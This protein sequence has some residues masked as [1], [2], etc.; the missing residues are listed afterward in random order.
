MQ[1]LTFDHTDIT[2]KGLAV[3]APLRRLRDISLQSPN[4]TAAGLSSLTGMT[5]I[6]KLVLNSPTISRRE[7]EV[8]SQLQSLKGL[9]IYGG[10]YCDLDVAPLAC[11]T[12]L[13]ELETSENERINGTY[14][15]FLQDRGQLKNLIPG[16]SVTDDGV[17]CIT[18]LSTLTTLFLEGPF[19]NIGLRQ[20]RELKRLETLYITSR[21]VTD[22]GVIV[23][24]ALPDLRRLGLDVPRLTDSCACCAATLPQTRIRGDF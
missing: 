19:S 20:V 3:L 24:A 9:A 12:R 2:D 14:A 1:K 16:G 5:S 6:R 22:D 7:L 11:L 23:I 8:V 21:Q 18:R 10:T 13:E 17:S 15:Q 4:I